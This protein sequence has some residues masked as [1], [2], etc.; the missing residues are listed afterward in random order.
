MDR[1]TISQK[2]LCGGCQAGCGR[3]CCYGVGLYRQPHKRLCTAAARPVAVGCA[4]TALAYTD[5][6]TKGFVR[7]LPGRLRTAVL[8]LRWRVL[9]QTTTRRNIPHHP[10]PHTD[11]SNTQHTSKLNSCLRTRPRWNKEGSTMAKEHACSCVCDGEEGEGRE[12]I[13]V[14]VTLR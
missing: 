13:Q 14:G 2:A 5:N 1:Q 9:R 12:K 10:Q 3:L 4:A 7:R 8:L 6:L 11:T